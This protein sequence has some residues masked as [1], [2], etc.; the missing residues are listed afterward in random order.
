MIRRA[1]LVNALS[2]P[3]FWHVWGRGRHGFWVEWA[4]ASMGQL[5]T[6]AWGRGHQ[7]LAFWDTLAEGHSFSALYGEYLPDIFTQPQWWS[8]QQ[9]RWLVKSQPWLRPGC[10]SP[11]HLCQ[12]FCVS[13]M[14]WWMATFE[15][16]DLWLSSW[17]WTVLSE[18]G[19]PSTWMPVRV[20]LVGTK[21][22]QSLDSQ[23]L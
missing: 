5:L 2:F 7:K 19:G 17:A 8:H 23:V 14:E 11:S 3:Y 10:L 9:I 18:V 1:S 6:R 15:V 4:S 20:V 21:A 12:L 16:M 13:P 22:V